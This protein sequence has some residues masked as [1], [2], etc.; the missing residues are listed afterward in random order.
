M[1]AQPTFWTPETQE[2]GLRYWLCGRHDPSGVV[3]HVL[4]GPRIR[5]L[6]LFERG[7]LVLETNLP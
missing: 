7:L 5:W 1:L 3:E 2:L 4:G 6:L